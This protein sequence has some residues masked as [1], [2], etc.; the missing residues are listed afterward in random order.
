MVSKTEDKLLELKE[1]LSGSNNGVETKIDKGNADLKKLL[2][3][4]PNSIT[5][6]QKKP[7]QGMKFK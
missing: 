4:Y 7:V 1:K 5:K 2:K 6:S 3:V